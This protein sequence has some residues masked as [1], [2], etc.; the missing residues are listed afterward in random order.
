MVPFHDVLARL[1]DHAGNSPGSAE[2]PPP[3]QWYLSRQRRVKTDVAMSLG[4][5]PQATASAAAAVSTPQEREDRARPA[6]GKK[7][8]GLERPAREDG[9]PQGSYW[10]ADSRGG[11]ESGA[12]RAGEGEKGDGG[13]WF[14]SAGT[15]EA[16]VEEM[17][18]WRPTKDAAIA[19]DLRKERNKGKVGSSGAG[20]GEAPPPKA[21][22]LFSRPTPP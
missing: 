4:Q 21:P 19:V 3:P 5:Q 2:A 11:P 22:L 13:L 6:A 12:I 8:A 18:R 17:G 9:A 10:F 1:Y 16:A 20:E 14:A 7:I 15:D